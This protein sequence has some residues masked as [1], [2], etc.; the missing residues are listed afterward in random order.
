MKLDKETKLTLHFARI[1]HLLCKKLLVVILELLKNIVIL[2]KLVHGAILL[3]K[4]VL[5]RL[6]ALGPIV[7]PEVGV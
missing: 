7:L 2:K 3:A 5:N 1:R 4:Q 6:T